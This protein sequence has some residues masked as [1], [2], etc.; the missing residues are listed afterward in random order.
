MADIPGVT[1]TPLSD[2]N[3]SLGASQQKFYGA[4]GSQLATR[5]AE[6]VLAAAL[7]LAQHGLS[8]QQQPIASA[9]DV[10]L[11]MGELESRVRQATAAGAQQQ[12]SAAQ[13]P[14]GLSLHTH[15]RPVID[16]W[17]QPFAGQAMVSRRVVDALASPSPAIRSWSRGVP[18]GAPPLPTPPEAIAFNLADQHSRET[19]LQDNRLHPVADGIRQDLAARERRAKSAITGSRGVLGP[20]GCPPTLLKRCLAAVQTLSLSHFP[21]PPEFEKVVER[22]GFMQAAEMPVSSDGK[23]ALQCLRCAV[24]AY[25]PEFDWSYIRDL[26]D[27]VSRL[28]DGP[29][30]AGAMLAASHGLALLDA[31]SVW[32]RG[33]R[34][35]ERA[36]SAIRDGDVSPAAPP[37]PPGSAPALV[38]LFADPAAERS[39]ILRGV[40]DARQQNTR[41][42]VAAS[43]L[44]SPHP[45]SPSPPPPQ[46][47]QPAPAGQ[48]SARFLG[49]T[50]LVH[51]D[52]WELLFP[53]ACQFYAIAGKCSRATC[54]KKHEQ[55][56]R[57]AV[58]A[59]VLAVGGKVI[60]SV[61]VPT[62]RDG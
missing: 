16:E 61:D 3:A 4:K 41:A 47:G 39:A 7:V 26:E 5:Y 60:A 55:L 54:T 42:A 36:A 19:L 1:G 24:A 6:R 52:A 48:R 23:I 45:L 21:K 33:M 27:A 49:Y 18:A 30:A 46:A 38:Q 51:S 34:R 57:A 32:E 8:W 56:S 9:D 37:T 58:D 2:V 40:S 43:L 22:S 28:L 15:E 31:Q 20:G 12:H 10:L 25:W 62:L 44:S 50:C 59:H 17:N 14:P 13:T 11:A 53:G 35:I 29:K